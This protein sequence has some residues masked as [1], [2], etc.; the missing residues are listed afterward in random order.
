M[1]VDYRA[2]NKITVKNRYPLPCIDDGLDQLKNFVYFTKLDLC[3]GYYQIRVAE[4]DAWKT[5]FKTKTRLFEWLVMA[6]GICNATSTFM[7]VMND[8][9]RPF[10][11]DFVI[12]Y[13]DGII[14]F[15]GTW[16]G[17]VRHVKK[18]FHTFQRENLYVK[19]SKCEFGKTTLMYLGHIVGGGQLKIVPSK[20]DVT[21]HWHEPKSV[22]EIRSFL[23]AVQYW[24]SFISSL[25]FI[26]APLHALTSVK[27][28][29]Q[30]GGKKQKYF[31]TLK[32]NIS[33]IPV[34]TLSNL[35]QA[36]EIE[37]DASG[38]A[39]SVVLMQYCK[40]I[41]YH[42]ENFNQFVV[43]YP[44]YDNELYALVQSVNK[45]KHYLL[46]NKTIIHVDHQPLQ[47]LQAQTKMQQS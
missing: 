15:R 34:L 23:G 37:T 12:V 31:D 30:W 6:F 1:C 5:A 3:N 41:C 40:P 35:Q 13:L 21:V 39:M 16:D 29:F 4:Q 7:C 14:I 38:Y 36:F 46:G 25:L 9:F 2:L 8:V 43:N 47:Y 20:I 32:E 24:R 26:A 11:D 19:L 10:L 28:T 17:H 18:V 22:T 42:S 33:N 44:T 45:W 27:N